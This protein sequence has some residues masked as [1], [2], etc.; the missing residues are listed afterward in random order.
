M[1]RYAYQLKL[2]VIHKHRENYKPTY[3]S[4]TYGIKYEIIE[5]DL[6]NINYMEK[7]S[8]R[9]SYRKQSTLANSS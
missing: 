6:N 4:R 7:N 2:E 3:L 5:I 9:G 1:S 8:T